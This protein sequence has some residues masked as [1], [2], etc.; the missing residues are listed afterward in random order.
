MTTLQIDFST[1]FQYQSSGVRNGELIL[2]LQSGGQ[3]ASLQNV[4]IDQFH[5][6]SASSALRFVQIFNSLDAPPASGPGT[7]PL[8]TFPVPAG[9]PFC[10]QAPE[11]GYLV[12]LPI[13]FGWWVS[14]TG[15]QYTAGADSLFWLVMQGRA[16]V[17]PP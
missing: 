4:T 5:G 10:W 15:P 1:R 11:E 17:S 3:G 8:I 12:E 16:T 6:Y 9:M 13:N 2:E 14:T 7:I